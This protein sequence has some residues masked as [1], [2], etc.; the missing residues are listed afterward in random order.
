[1]CVKTPRPVKID[2]WYKNAVFE[3]AEASSFFQ[4]NF[5]EPLWELGKYELVIL[6]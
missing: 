2:N 5:L 1:M 3:N 6:I 4:L